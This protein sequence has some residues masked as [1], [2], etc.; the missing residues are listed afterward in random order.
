[1]MDGIIFDKDLT[2]ADLRAQQ[3]MN[4][5]V[6]RGIK[7]LEEFDK[8]W[9]LKVDV[10]TLDIG[11]PKQCICGQVFLEMI[12]EIYRDSHVYYDSGFQYVV[13]EYLV[14]RSE[15]CAIYGFAAQDHFN[16]GNDLSDAEMA[17]NDVVRS[18]FYGDIYSQF[19]Y[20]ACEWITQIIK[21]KAENGE[22]L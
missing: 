3:V 4:E 21:H 13:E 9:Y 17:M 12:E 11:D 18:P 7:F 14:D 5:N 15:V 10:S 1:M 22:M 16:V 6:Q 19:E 20:L 2:P 8:K